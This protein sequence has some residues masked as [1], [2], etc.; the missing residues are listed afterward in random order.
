[1]CYFSIKIILCYYLKV[2]KSKKFI[3]SPKIGI[4][5]VSMNNSDDNIR[6]LNEE[7]IRIKNRVE[8]IR[9]KDRDIIFKKLRDNRD[10]E[11]IC[12]NDCSNK[13][14]KQDYKEYLKSVAIASGVLSTVIISSYL[15]Y[16]GVNYI[17]NKI[18]D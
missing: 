1:M 2:S 5:M 12:L 14:K 16:Q 18:F 11:D 6:K 17:V 9:S 8:Y 3:N 7:I 10:L 13:Q 4:F 15:Y